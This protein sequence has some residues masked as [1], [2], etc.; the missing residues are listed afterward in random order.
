MNVI[1][2]NLFSFL[3]SFYELNFCLFFMIFNNTAQGLVALQVFHKFLHTKMWFAAA[4]LEKYHS[5]TL[6]T[7]VEEYRQNDG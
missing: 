2:L 4:F 6:Y 5:N 1:T 3:F 7:D